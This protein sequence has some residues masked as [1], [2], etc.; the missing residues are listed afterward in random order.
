MAETA[1][2]FIR[3]KVFTAIVAIVVG[4]LTWNVNTTYQVSV[5]LAEINSSVSQLVTENLVSRTAILETLVT[6]NTID[7]EKMKDDR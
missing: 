1:F 5:K 7:I 3:N 6:R 2:V 4:L